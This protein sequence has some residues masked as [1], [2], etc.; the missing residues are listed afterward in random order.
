MEQEECGD[1]EVD[2]NRDWSNA[3]GGSL[4]LKAVAVIGPKQLSLGEKLSSV[5]CKYKTSPS[6]GGREHHKW[7]NQ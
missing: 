1:G 5:N 3:R 4:D 2:Q 6:D 7:R